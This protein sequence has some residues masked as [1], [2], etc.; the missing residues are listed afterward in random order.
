MKLH[1]ATIVLYFVTFALQAQEFRSFRWEE[2]YST[3]VHEHATGWYD[4]F[5]FTPLGSKGAYLSAGGEVRYQYFRYTNEEWGDAPE[6]KDGFVLSRLLFHSDF[7]VNNHIRFFVQLQSSLSDGRVTEPPPIEQ[8]E[9]DLHQAFVDVALVK[10]N[11]SVLTL[12]VGRQELGYG[13]SRLISPREGPNNR[14]AFDGAKVFFTS[15]SLKADLFW[16]DYVVSNRG[17]LN[18]KMLNAGIRLWGA[19]LVFN[20]VPFFKNLDLY[21]LGLQKENSAWSDV[22]GRE[23]RHTIGARVSGKNGK[24]AYDFEGVYQFGTMTDYTIS[25]WT[26]S[27]SNT[28]SLFGRPTSPYFGLKTEFISGDKSPADDRIE[29]FNPLFP[30]G[31][32]FGYAALIGPSNLFDIHPSLSVPIMGKFLVSLDHDI[33][34]RYSVGDGIYNPGARIIYNAGAS[35]EKFIGHQFGGTFEFTGNKFVYLRAEG[36][37]FKPGPYIKSMGAGKQIFYSGITATL[38]F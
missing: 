4:K 14:Q 28:Y 31:A 17:I 35:G 26:L 16:T 22:V 15:Q 27:S 37:W 34:W 36:T 25:A 18:D 8:N 24:W 19:Y 6:D 29:S 1:S 9:L 7:H 10:K 2:D 32:Y 30:K 20:K 38:K 13:S 5:K 11:T 23:I 21:Y 3:S 33:F 12:R